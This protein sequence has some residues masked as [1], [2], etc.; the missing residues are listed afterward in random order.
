MP[1]HVLGLATIPGYSGKN[2]SSVA[3]NVDY[4]SPALLY[5]RKA[6]ADWFRCAEGHVRG[7]KLRIVSVSTASAIGS[8][9]FVSG[10]EV[11]FSCALLLH[12]L[13]SGFER[14]GILRE[15]D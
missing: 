14:Y 15:T 7:D 12:Q 1:I 9:A 10:C 11:R 3:T 4:H 5:V 8:P 2:G 6:S 13:M